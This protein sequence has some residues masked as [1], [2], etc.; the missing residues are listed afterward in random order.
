MFFSLQTPCQYHLMKWMFA[1]RVESM[2]HSILYILL[3]FYE[4]S[5]WMSLIKIYKYNYKLSVVN[6]LVFLNVV[7]CKSLLFDMHNKKKKNL[8]FLMYLYKIRW[9][10]GMVCLNCITRDVKYITF[11]TRSLYVACRSHAYFSDLQWF[12][13]FRGIGQVW[14]IGY[15]ITLGQTENVKISIHG[16]HL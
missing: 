8:V 2:K 14:H 16:I 15:I 4:N 10:L 6:Q 5:T 9:A 11:C 7:W 12:P 1:K 3:A 13:A